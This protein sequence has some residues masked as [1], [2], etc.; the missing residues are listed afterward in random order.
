M[1]ISYSSLENYSSV[2]N[3]IPYNRNMIN[4]CNTFRVLCLLFESSTHVMILI[5]EIDMCNERDAV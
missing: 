1:S 2:E 5:S 3:V 4:Y